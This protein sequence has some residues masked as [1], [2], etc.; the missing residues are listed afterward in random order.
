MSGVLRMQKREGRE[1]SSGVVAPPRPGDFEE[2]VCGEGCCRS[3]ISV[4]A[5]FKQQRR[6]LV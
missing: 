3:R 4:N 5:D 1:K 6:Q 2:T